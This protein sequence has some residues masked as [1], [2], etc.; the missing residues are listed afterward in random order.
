[1]ITCGD[2]L[3][4]L[5]VTAGSYV[6]EVRHLTEGLDEKRLAWS[7]E[8]GR[9]SMAQCF[10]HLVVS[11]G[12]YH[13]RIAAAIDRNPSSSASTSTFRPTWIGRKFVDTMRD[14]TGQRRI[15]AP[16]QF[17]PSSQPGP[18]S[19]ERLTASLRE[20]DALL[21][22]AARADIVRARLTSPVVPLLKLNVGEALE[23]QVVHIARHLA[24]AR[25]VREDAAFPS[26]E[27]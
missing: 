4:S 18:G 12:L 17:R 2:H 27:A 25:R 24:Q 15:K 5:R 1:M 16:R 11:A 7:S 19:A 26:S 8:P 23:L 21:E 13:P 10:E 6:D 22:R 20:L 3:S 14:T 9:W